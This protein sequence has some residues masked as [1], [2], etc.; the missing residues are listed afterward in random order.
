MPSHAPFLIAL[1]CGFTTSGVATWAARAANALAAAGRHAGIIVH[2]PLRGH[3][4][5]TPSLHPAVRL[6]DASDLAPFDEASGRIAPHIALYRDAVEALAP[7]GVCVCS[8]NLH[9]DSYGAFA[10]VALAMPERLRLLGWQHSAI[11][12]DARILAR[13]EPILSRFMAVSEHIGST[14]RSRLPTR[15]DSVVAMPY[16]VDVPAVRPAR[17]PR[18]GRPLGII[19]TG[20]IEHEQKRVNA[21]PLLSDRLSAMGVDHRLTIVGDGPAAAE[22]DAACASRPRVRRLA[23]VPPQHVAPLLDEHDVFVLG[24]RYEGLSVSMLEAMARACA[25]V[26]IAVRSGSGE[27]IRD[28]VNGVLCDAADDAPPELVGD[29]LAAG[30][31]RAIGIG[32]AELGAAAFETAL[33]RYG[34]RRYAERLGAVIDEA[35]AEPARTWP[36]DRA[37]AFTS[38]TSADSGSVPADGAERMARA[39]QSLAGRSVLLHGAGRHTIE[40]A[41]IL[42][43]SPASIVGVCDDDPARRG[44]TLWNWPIMPP[45]HAGRTG[46]SDV[47]ISSWMH[48]EAIWERRAVYEAQGLRVHR[49]YAP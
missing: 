40:L 47:V 44:R 15:A 4:R 42:A 29:A 18:A 6:F 35:A 28:G 14:L 9:G 49:L 24:S 31:L 19:Y 46:A 26:V 37:C 36:A 11:E 1:P 8:P 5:L 22:I 3:S 2:A 32:V 12:Y 20:R 21:L 41:A 33:A 16:C 7:G 17:P 43:S 10:A 30:V 13:Y 48:E 23:A 25:P 45:A 39:L 34:T 38:N 27:A